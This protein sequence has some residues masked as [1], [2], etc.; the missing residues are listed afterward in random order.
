MN[1]LVR[2][3]TVPENLQAPPARSA[4]ARP[5]HGRGGVYRPSLPRP[6]PGRGLRVGGDHCCC[7]V[8]PKLVLF[9]INFL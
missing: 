8:L 9:I 7:E 1:T 4:R 5:G 2:P 6:P 3:R